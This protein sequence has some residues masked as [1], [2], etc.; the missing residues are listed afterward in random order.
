MQASNLSVPGYWAILPLRSFRHTETVT[1]RAVDMKEFPSIQGID[2][3]EH[4]SNARSPGTYDGVVGWYFHRHQQDNLLVMRGER[5]TTL[6]SPLYPGREDVF[7]VSPQGI[8]HNGVVACSEPA[9]LRWEPLTFHRVDSG[10]DGSLSL[11][12][13]VRL[14][15]FDIDHEFD[16]HQVDPKTHTSV[17]IRQGFEDQM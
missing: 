13:A 16:I 10:V 15:G 11:N 7:V 6:R 14:Q 17:V 2:H 3:V 1:F 5:T 4:Q 12:F 8:T 9:V